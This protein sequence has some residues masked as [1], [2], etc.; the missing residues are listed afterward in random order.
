MPALYPDQLDDFVNLTLKKFER[1][2]WVDLSLDLQEFICASR[3][4]RKGKVRSMGGSKFNWKLQVRNTGT[5]RHTE[6]F[7]EDVTNIVNLSTQ[8]EVDYTKQT[9]N[10]SYDRDE[11]VFQTTPEEI[12][13]VINMRRHAAYNDYFVLME[14]ALWS[15]PASSSLSP[16]QPY[17]IPFWIQKN[18]TAGFTGG[19]P[20]GFSSGAAGVSTTTYPNWKNYSFPYTAVTRDDFVKKL[21][22]AHT[23]CMFKAPHSFNELAGGQDYE[24]F[25]TYAV[26]EGLEL[27]VE[28]RND[29]LGTDLGTYNGGEIMYRRTPIIWAPY[30]TANDTSNPF[31]GV[32]WKTM[33]LATKKGKQG[34]QWDPAEKAP[35][36]HSVKIVHGDGW[37][38]IACENRRGNFVGYVA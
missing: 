11:E 30:L 12:V 24:F 26:L 25:T 16:R 36:Q 17:G 1:N 27:I 37:S 10:F 35:N 14:E 23:F 31:Y 34:I 2:K 22:K 18:A 32:N 5:A 4:F 33:F 20:S 3:L 38:Q 21:K 19:D 8:A 13:N 7:D 29:N 15:A 9:V 28:S 6:M